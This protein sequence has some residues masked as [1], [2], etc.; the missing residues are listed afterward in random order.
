MRTVWASEH[1][2]RDLNRR[3]WQWASLQ[4]FDNLI[5]FGPCATM[6]VFDGDKLIAVMVYHNF[7]SRAGV[8]EVSGAATT[9]EWLKRRVL[10]EM[11]NVPFDR[12]GVQTVVMR[13]SEASET[14]LHRILP[15]LGF[16]GC[17]LPRLRGRDEDEIVYL[18][19]DD[20]WASKP[21]SGKD[22]DHGDV[23]GRKERQ[24]A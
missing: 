20:V 5:G 15:A 1:D 2:D 18:L 13:V 23:A 4:L 19:H 10:R 9:K 7:D 8:I 24:A 12:M 3:L 14:G 17:R 11:F 22:P 21:I 6:G 16:V